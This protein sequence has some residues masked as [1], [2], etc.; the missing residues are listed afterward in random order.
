MSRLYEESFKIEAVKML[1]R[2]RK[3]VPQIARELGVSSTS[4]RDWKYKYGDEEMSPP[5][6]VEASKEDLIAE[7]SRLTRE[8]RDVQEQREILK[9]AAAILGR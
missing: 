8:L 7:V 9:K 2:T 4:L 5:L 1:Y 3:S 6:D